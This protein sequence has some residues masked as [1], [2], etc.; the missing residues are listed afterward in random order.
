MLNDD[1]TLL[2]NSGGNPIGILLIVRLGYI[3]FLTN[4]LELHVL[5]VYEE[6]LGPYLA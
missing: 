2:K 4:I 1:K 3:S 6:K 5:W